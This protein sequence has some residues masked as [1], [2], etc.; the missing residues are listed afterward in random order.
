MDPS[1]F[2]NSQPQYI[3]PEGN[4]HGRGKFELV[5][6][7]IGTVIGAGFAVGCSRGL[8]G[9]VMNP[10]TRKLVRFHVHFFV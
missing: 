7:H 8:I 9:E 2:R 10:D 6:G 1:V 4:E 3:M 5:L